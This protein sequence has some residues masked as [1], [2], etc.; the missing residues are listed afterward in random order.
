M[1]SKPYRHTSKRHPPPETPDLEA[2]DDDPSDN[3]ITSS[4]I[5]IKTIWLYLGIAIIFLFGTASG[6]KLG[7]SINADQSAPTR[8]KAA[9]Q[10]GHMAGYQQGF[11][12]GQRHQV[13]QSIDNPLFL[14]E[15]KRPAN[16]EPVQETPNSTNVQTNN[17][18]NE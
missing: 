6:L 10:D 18:T 13:S 14:Y 15:E 11:I 3:T 1:S 12:E 4:E 9:W 5:N 8:I 16:S 7:R 17:S 2:D